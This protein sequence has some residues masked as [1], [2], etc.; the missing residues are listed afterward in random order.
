MGKK[1]EVL[2]LFHAFLA[3]YRKTVKFNL[4]I[5]EKVLD[6]LFYF[7]DKA[8]SHDLTLLKYVPHFFISIIRLF[9]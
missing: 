6:K 7:Q 4:D 8:I 1:K 5:I 3:F 2:L 9:F